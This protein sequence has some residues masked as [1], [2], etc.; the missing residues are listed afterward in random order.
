MIGPLQFQSQGMLRLGVFIW[1][2]FAILTVIGFL[3]KLNYAKAA[4]RSNYIYSHVDW[5]QI[6]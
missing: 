2:H 1:M 4:I 6:H 3:D 5:G